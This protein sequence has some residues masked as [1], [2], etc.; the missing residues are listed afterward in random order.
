MSGLLVVPCW[1]ELIITVFNK[2][3]SS[4][5]SSWKQMEGSLFSDIVLV[6]KSEKRWSSEPNEIRLTVRVGVPAL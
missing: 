3:D 1:L 5:I 2:I 6:S 4:L